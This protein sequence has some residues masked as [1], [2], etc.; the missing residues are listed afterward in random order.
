MVQKRISYLS[1]ALLIGFLFFSLCCG[2]GKTKAKVRVTIDPRVELMSLI[3]RLAGNPEYTM[4]RIASYNKDIDSH[5]SA[6]ED[7]EVVRMA[8]KLRETRGVSYDAVMGMAVHVTDAFSL[9]E[10]IPFDPQPVTLDSRWTPELAREFLDAARRFVEASDFKGFIQNHDELYALAASRMQT[11]ME[12]HGVVD[13]F[14]KFFGSRPGARFELILGMLNGPGNYGA[15]VKPSDKDEILYCILG[16]WSTDEEGNPQFGQQVL[17]TVV[18]E[19]SHSYC[20]PLVEKHI[21]ELE[22][23]GKEIFSRVQEAMSRMAYGNWE[24]MM[25][26]SLV[27]ASV[28]RYL[29]AK[30]GE[31]AAQKGIQSEIKRQFFWMEGLSGLLGEYEEKRE[32]YAS[33]D[34]FFPEITSFFKSCA[35]KVDQDMKA[36]E[37]DRQ[38]QMEKL[39]A[40]SPRIVSLLPPNGARDVDPNF[41]AIV[42]TFDRPM[43]D[44]QWAVMR[45]NDKFPEKGGEVFYDETKKVFTI[46]VKLKPDTEYELGLNAD[47]VYGFASEAGDPL[48][49][50]VIRFKTKRL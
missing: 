41:R 24:T 3:F 34:D 49:P 48:Y 6:F 38:V 36:F 5:F 23:P 42:V 22:T 35:S 19:F 8:K 2:Q 14:D 33:L 32:T 28:I 20:N 21:A 30:F 44:G 37:Q 1:R 25:K 10:R 15:R 45:F 39:K 9:K 50:V 26:E 47:G 16:V 17:P 40:N 12:E 4:G 43:K 46:P 13:W 29:R 7:H 11:V 31:E 27:R 18:H